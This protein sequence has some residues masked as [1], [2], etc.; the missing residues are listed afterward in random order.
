MNNSWKE[1]FSFS[2]KERT[3]I[4]VLLA[5]TGIAYLLPCLLPGPSFKPD[6]I[7]FERLQQQLAALR[8]AQEADVATIGSTSDPSLEERAAITPND[9]KHPV[10]FE[11]DPN[12]LS[13]AGWKR[14]GLR[15]KT[16]LT[17]QHYLSKGGQF[18]KPEDLGK[19]YG[20]RAEEFTR[21]I[22]YVKI[23]SRKPALPESND[24]Y[25]QK[26]YTIYERRSRTIVPLD[27]NT[28]DTTAL[29][30]LPGIGP[31]LA[32]R[33]VSFRERLGGFYTAEQIGETYGLPDST[34]QSL[35]PYLQCKAHSVRTIDLNSA[36]I[37]TLKQHPYIRWKMARAIIQ[38]RQQH[39]AFRSVEELGKIESILP[40][41]LKKVLPYLR[42]D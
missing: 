28:A 32:Q 18:R 34:F 10:L 12:T 38:Y 23:A 40:E 4:I 9:H 16:I 17:I 41:D 2:K 7:A 20:M 39:G 3:G 33:I 24:S 19:I 25:P 8:T 36:G 27:V 5:L 26:P 14:L 22:P 11:F 42:V 30:A 29:I 37:D 35:K 13:G 6:K 31:K 21:L 1:Y 15:D